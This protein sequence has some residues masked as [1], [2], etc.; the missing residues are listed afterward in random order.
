M[1]QC[2][3]T[4]FSV[5]YDRKIREFCLEFLSF[6][7]EFEHRFEPAWRLYMGLTREGLQLHLSEHRSDASPGAKIFIPVQ[8]IAL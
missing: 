4:Y 8:N 1:H 2:S 5:S 7:V 6:S 3:E